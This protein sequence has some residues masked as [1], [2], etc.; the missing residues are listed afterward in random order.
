[1]FTFM[2]KGVIKNVGFSTIFTMQIGD[3][4]DLQKGSR[5]KY[6]TEDKW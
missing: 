6:Y 5:R 4:F 3:K 2:I 1:M